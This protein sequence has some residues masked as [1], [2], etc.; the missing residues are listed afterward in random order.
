MKLIGISRVKNEIDIIEAFVRHNARHVDK[1]ILLD[2]G[3][4]DGSYEV[5]CALRDAGLPLVVL[6]EASIG[7]EQSRYMTRLLHMAVQQFGADWVVP[8]DADEFLEPAEG[9]SLADILSGHEAE[10]AA[11]AWA[12]FAWRPEDEAEEEINPAVRLRW[13]VPAYERPAYRM[14]S[15]ALVPAALFRNGHI[16][17]TQGNH[18]VHR[19][20]RPVAGRWLDSVVLCHFP[21]RS[22]QQYAA[23]IALGYLQYCATPHWDPRIGHHY[24]KPFRQL[25]GG[26]DQVAGMMA[27]DSRRYSLEEDAPD[28]GAPQEAPLR[29]AG[30]ALS[31][32]PRGVNLLANILF[33]AEA[34]ARER[35]EGAAELGSLHRVLAAATPEIATASSSDRILA[36]QH[37]VGEARTSQQKMEAARLASQSLLAEARDRLAAEQAQLA[38]EQA[39][40]AR[41]TEDNAVLQ[42]RL[43]E[44]EAERVKLREVMYQQAALLTSRTFR[45]AQG[46]QVRLVRSGFLP[47][48]VADRLSQL[49]GIK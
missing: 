23:K 21:I 3:S 6:R 46:L 13:R 45:L 25:A 42:K 9:R 31:F 48:P 36:L 34:I 14:L 8:L 18:A 32:T 17:L 47:R 16:G 10:P 39:E 29:Y 7:Y 20:G 38:A 15:K 33:S 1:L 40:R 27:R 49:F 19:D 26:L 30:G 12:N 11:L 37:L 44:L 24:I 2:D 41:L 28:P 43:L 35:A 4:T 22:L 5:L